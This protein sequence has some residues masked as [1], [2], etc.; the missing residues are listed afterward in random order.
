MALDEPFYISEHRK[1]FKQSEGIPD[2]VVSKPDITI[3][4]VSAARHSILEA[5]EML[6]EEGI[7]CNVVHIYKLKPLEIN[8]TVSS[9]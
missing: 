5:V 3:Y 6:K 7:R 2:I 4:G 8:L 9:F 1:S